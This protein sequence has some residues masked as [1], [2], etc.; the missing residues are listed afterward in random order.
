[1]VDG[2][3]RMV[4]SQNGGW[5]VE[6]VGGQWLGFLIG[7]FINRMF[8]AEEVWSVFV[9]VFDIFLIII[10][11]MIIILFVFFIFYFVSAVTL[12]IYT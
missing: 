4:G 9:I 10:I 11:A 3:V 6:I 1:M 2:P 8:F 12:F 7:N 5:W